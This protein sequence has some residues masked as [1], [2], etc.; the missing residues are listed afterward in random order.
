MGRPPIHKKAMTNAERQK[1]YCRRFAR[2]HPAPKTLAKQQR[3][4]EREAHLGDRI[5]RASTALG[6]KLY[7]VVYMDPASRFDVWSRETG[8]DRAADNHYPTEFWDAIAARPPS[9]YEGSILFCWSTRPQMLNTGRMVEDHWGFQYKTCIGW[10]KVLRGTGL[11]TIDNCE[12]LLVFSRGKPVWPGA[13]HPGS[14][15]D[16]D[17]GAVGIFIP[18][19]GQDPAQPAAQRKARVLCRNDRAAMAQHAEARNVL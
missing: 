11:I 14:G 5:A 9:A 8:L 18:A 1:R 2:S 12:L 7:G 10:D 4:A 3:R 17:R 13:G 6:E 16:R 19:G 15:A